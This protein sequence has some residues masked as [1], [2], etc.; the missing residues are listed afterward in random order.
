MH[1][2]VRKDCTLQLS[3][4]GAKSFNLVRSEPQ[5]RSLIGIAEEEFESNQKRFDSDG[6]IWLKQPVGS[7]D[8]DVSQF[9]ISFISQSRLEQ[10]ISPYFSLLHYAEGE[11]GGW[12]D[13]AIL[14]RK[15]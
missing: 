12:Q 1:R 11:L 10:V 6:F 13:L 8:I 3:L 7:S 4:H 9:G 5:R 14:R 2:I 15:A